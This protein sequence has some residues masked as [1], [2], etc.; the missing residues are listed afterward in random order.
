[1]TTPEVCPRCGHPLPEGAN[2]CPNCGS[3]VGLPLASERRVVTVVFADLAGSTELAANLDPER[4]REVLAAFHSLVTDEITALGGRAELFIGDAVLGVFGV[5]VVHDDDALR[6]VR[7]GLEIVNRAS[8]LGARLG[9]AVPI[10]VRV[11]VNTGRVAVGTATDR[12]IVIGAEVN[13]GARLQ[14]AAL[15]GEVLVGASTR[16]LV[17]NGVRFGQ[18]RSVEAKGLDGAMAA[19]PTLALAGPPT[20]RSL[21]L[22]DRRRELAL[23]SDTFA[24]VRVRERAHLVTLLGEPGIGKS[25]VVEEFLG[26]LGDDVKVLAGRSS[27]FEEEVTFWPVAQM[28]Y[29]EIGAD[30]DTSHDEVADRLRALVSERVAPED[31]DDAVR[32]LALA[33]GVDDDGASEEGRYHA[34]EIRAGLLALLAGLASGGPVVLVFEDLHEADPLLLDLIEQLVK[35]ARRVPLMVL[36]VARWEFLQER[37]SWAGGIADAVTLWVEPL[38][39]GQ[40]AELAMEAGD[41]AYEES[42]RVAKHAGGNP[43]FVVEIVGM[44]RREERDLPLR[45]P[46]ASARLLPPTVQAVIAARI[47]QLSPPARSLVQRASVFPRGR[48]DLEELSLIVEPRRELLS[49]AEDEGLL[50]PDEDRPGL[51]RFGSDI[52]RDVAYDTLA[53]RERQR[54]HLRVANKLSEGETADRYPRTIAFHLEQAAW[55]SLDL[56]PR[57]RDIAERAVEALAQAGDI[58]RRRIESRSAAELY[59][60]ALALAGPD[61]RWG[62]REGRIL[63]TLGEARYWLGEFDLAEAALRRALALG[64]ETNDRI[65]AHASRF[66]A[67]ITLT[68]HGDAQQAEALFDRSLEAARRVGDPFGLART[69]LMAG[70]VPFWRSE[71]DHAQTM[72][73]EALEIARGNEAGDAW[74]ASRAL[75][76]IANVL[77]LAADEEEALAVGLEALAVGEAAN[78]AFT[79]AVAHETV[80]ASLRRLMRLDEALEHSEPAIRTFRELG[81]RWELASSLGDRGAIHRMAGRLE[82][83]ENDLREAFVLCRDLQERALVTW[84]AAELVRILALR[85]DTSSARKVLSDPSTLLA[86]GEQGSATALLM[87]GAVLALAEGDRETALAKSIAAIEA[88]SGPRGA[89]N[90]RAGLIWWVGKVFGADAAGGAEVLEGAR[91]ALEAHHW[92]QA[93]HEPDLAAD[94]DS[95]LAPHQVSGLQG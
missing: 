8:R 7:A 68:I 11:G 10:Q 92:L 70:W 43:F 87:A 23:L 2:F 63:G 14:Q 94:L 40:A 91:A 36:C 34:A 22:V 12:N 35:E 81:S 42:E 5:P 79:A 18:V 53:K 27:P 90:A 45:G 13:I 50:L 28:V 24:R 57:E 93:L 9:L 75:V 32:R 83:A 55:A 29:H 39:L 58:A 67:D 65:C 59:E 73:R 48:F 84:T 33:L 19:W 30:R 56:N 78:Q 6:G 76:G 95:S 86:D 64:G 17:G 37:P 60:R 20:R 15:P 89:P 25:R 38:T 69:L 74:A 51:W 49:E 82:E 47:D 52:L 85:G 16:H 61:E 66:L 26:G 54:L 71:L 88:E 62:E 46:A 1:M 21:H 72:F 77:S 4:F 80:A 31:A 3:P 41:L 44:M